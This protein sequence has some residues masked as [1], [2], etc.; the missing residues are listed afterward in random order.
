ME[1]QHQLVTVV[2]AAAVPVHAPLL[3]PRPRRAVAVVRDGGRRSH[4][5][6]DLRLA[7]RFQIDRRERALLPPYL[8]GAFAGAGVLGIAG[9]W[10]QV[11]IANSDPMVAALCLA[12]IDCRLSERKRLAWWLLVLAALGR[13][14][15]WPVTVLYAAW[16][17]RATPW[18]RR[19]LVGGLAAIPLAWFVIPALTSPTW[20]IAGDIAHGNGA[21]LTGNRFTGTLNRFTG[22][23]EL[24]TQLAALSAIALS[25]IL[26]ARRW[27]VLIGAAG[28]WLATDIAFAYRG[29]PTPARYLFEPAAVMIV[30]AGAALGRVLVI[31]STRIL[32][33]VA[34]AAGI[35]ILVVTLVPI[36]RMRVQSASTGIARGRTSAR[37]IARLETLIHREGARR[38]LACGQPVTEVPFHSILAWELGVNLNQVGWAALELRTRRPVVLFRPY[39][40]GWHLRPMHIPP[41]AR[42]RCV[43]VRTNTPSG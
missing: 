3:G 14:E 31:T 18:L 41:E 6:S 26:R 23:Y 5:G 42:S 24:P 36:A 34:A 16:E 13:P 22:L 33:H 2:E 12:C 15:V 32:L 21:V 9:Y 19:H 20:L 28:V 1:P 17:W 25:V 39:R 10:H 7:R 4:R 30:L 37:R 35:V 43:G 29:L 8:A 27:L 38:I 11:L 40:V